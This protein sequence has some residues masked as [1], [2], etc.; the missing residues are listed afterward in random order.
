MSQVGPFEL[1]ILLFLFVIPGVIVGRA[2]SARG[3]SGLGFGLLSACLSW[4]GL[5]LLL[6]IIGR[7]PKV[8]GEDGVSDAALNRLV[9]LTELRERGALTPE[10]YEAEKAKLL[11]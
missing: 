10:E 8:A 11:R 2:A 4:L 6:Y 3:M 7:Q 9:T 5:L 1:L